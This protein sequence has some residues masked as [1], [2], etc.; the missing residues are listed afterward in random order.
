[1][2]A[3]PGVG[4][5]ATVGSSV[6][7][8]STISSPTSARP[9]GRKRNRSIAGLDSSPGSQ[10][11]GDGEEGHDGRRRQPGVKRA[12]NECRQQ[13]LRCDVVQEPF[14]TCSRCRR[15]SLEC[16]IE[17]NFKRVGKRSKN[18][19]MER[20]I[21]E[22]RRQLANQTPTMPNHGLPMSVPLSTAQNDTM[23]Q[24]PSRLDQYMGSHEAVTSLLDLSK[25]GL[26]GSGAFRS[27]NS[28]TGTLRKI[29]DVTISHDRVTELF[30]QYVLPPTDVKS[31]S[32]CKW[33]NADDLIV[34]VSYFTFYHPFLPLLD[35]ERTPD[36]Y[37]EIS[38]LLF[39]TVISI[40]SRRYAFE[41]SLLN[42]LSAPVSRLVWTTIAEIP[43]VYHI[44]K[45]LSLL[46]TW[47]LPV[48]STSTD[49]TFMLSG[50]MM[51]IAM[52]IGLHRPSHAQDFTK[53]RVE[54]RDGEL[55]DRVKTWAACNI[56]CQ[57]VGTGY[58]QP[59]TTLYDWTLDSNGAKE[60]SYK[61]PEELESR[62]Q[63]EIF[64][65]KVTKALY[66]N[67]RDPVGLSRDDQRV[68]LTTL[69]VREFE[70][71]EENLGD[72]IS[73]INTLHLRAAGLHLRLSAFFNSNTTKDYRQDLLGLFFT[74]TSFLECALNLETSAGGVLSYASNYILQIIIAAGFTLLKLL[75]SFFANDIDLEHG[76]SLF[77]KTIWSIRAISV[78]SNDLPSRLAEVLAQLW[79]GGGAGSRTRS[80]SNSEMD[81]SLQL[82]VRCRMSMSLVFDSVWRWREEFQAKGRGNLESAVKNPTNPDSAAESSASSI[83][84]PSFAPPGISGA[85][86]LSGNNV[87]SNSFGESN[88][89][90][91]DPLNWMLDGLVDFPYSYTAVQTLES[92]GIA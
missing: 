63:I 40:A 59:V 70:E 26:D 72:N 43:H 53:F 73:P 7:G 10:E 31:E 13:K 76:K 29:E 20:E 91:F 32:I 85:V 28:L 22:L 41:P 11:D 82:K 5:L 54:L 14:S 75:N 84:D 80:P 77:N 49:P 6:G 90:V 52:Q 58:G 88:Y 34:G 64:C 1:M 18:A 81:S 48:S 4:G 46:C 36:H 30:N 47:P 9:G 8:G 16:K 50:V 79:R 78:T 44:V 92:Q 37:Y 24:A 27:P 68:A 74:T 15:L 89:E 55:R 21:I 65:D 69:L 83:V 23:Y 17:S 25:S 51:H 33:Q 42:N 35:P 61:L 12:C 57:S 67:R 39:W 71:L 87:P 86:T 3:S 19:E 62:L 2:D 45:A 56:V 38:P 60:A 66:S